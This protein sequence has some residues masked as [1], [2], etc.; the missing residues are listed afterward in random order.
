M[1][2]TNTVHRSLLDRMNWGNCITLSRR[3]IAEMLHCSAR[4]GGW[5][6]SLETSSHDSVDIDASFELRSSHAAS[7]AFLTPAAGGS[8]ART[9]RAAP[10]YGGCSDC[11]LRL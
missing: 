4:P 7:G 10:S 5:L 6:R 8:L 3:K 9:A 11:R 1:Q 2:V